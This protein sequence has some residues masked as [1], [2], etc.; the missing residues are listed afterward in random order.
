[1]REYW[2]LSWNKLPRIYLICNAIFF[3]IGFVMMIA[4]AI[5]ENAW[6][7]LLDVRALIIFP[8]CIGL[9]TFILTLSTFS[10]YQQY[11]QLR[12]AFE[13]SP[14]S[15]LLFHGFERAVLFEK[16][17]SSLYKAVFRSEVNGFIVIADIYEKKSVAFTLL[18]NQPRTF[19][20]PAFEK[21]RDLKINFNSAGVS[22]I[23]PIHS[24]HLPGAEALQQILLVLSLEMEKHNI[25]PS[26][27][28]SEYERKL[29][30]E[31]IQ[32]GVQAGVGV[33][34]QS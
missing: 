17:L 25:I 7:E 5:S 12:D 32:K 11:R 29:K 20:L 27:N 16:S 18:A 31:M 21:Y 33:G 23:V 1:M 26:E 4:F 34:H 19:A 2:R 30:S 10:G 28:I 8:F 3:I 13:R 22:L 6:H 9:S 15:D 14:F 24:S